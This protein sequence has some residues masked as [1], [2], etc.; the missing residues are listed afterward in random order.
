MSN[1][2][3]EKSSSTEFF[4]LLFDLVESCRERFNPGP[5][6]HFQHI[7]TCIRNSSPKQTVQCTPD[8]QKSTETH[9]K[10]RRTLCEFSCAYTQE[11]GD[12]VNLFALFEGLR[13]VE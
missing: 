8:A 3:S 13:V 12:P 6:A 5:S 11:S 1:L 7:F 2:W 9:G 4:Y 10:A